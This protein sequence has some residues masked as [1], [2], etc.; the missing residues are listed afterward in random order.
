MMNKK[1]HE[2]KQNNNQLSSFLAGFLFLGGLLVGSVAGAGMM[3]LLAPQSGKK[4]RK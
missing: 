2:V 1:K 3:L 4:T